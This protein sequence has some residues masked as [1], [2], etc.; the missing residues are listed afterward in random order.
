M[1]RFHRNHANDW[2]CLGNRH[3]G[4]LHVRPACHK[5]FDYP[6]SNYRLCFLGWLPSTSGQGVYRVDGIQHTA[7]LQAALCS[8]CSWPCLCCT[9]HQSWSRLPQE[10]RK[11]SHGNDIAAKLLR[12]NYSLLFV[13]VCNFVRSWDCT[14]W[15][16][17]H[18]FCWGSVRWVGRLCSSKTALT[19]FHIEWSLW[20]EQLCR[21]SSFCREKHW[22]SSRHGVY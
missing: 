2:D 9:L 15:A 5:S 18:D 13:K 22:S 4:A 20:F 8:N 1:T 11:S 19:T 21:P 10:S 16:F 12:M 6:F 7:S 3:W 17:F 14:M